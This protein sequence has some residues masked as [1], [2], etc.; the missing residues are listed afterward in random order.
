MTIEFGISDKYQTILARSYRPALR[1]EIS[2]YK[3]EMLRHNLFS[4]DL[5][6]LVDM[7]RT[8][9]L[10]IKPEDIESLPYIFDRQARRAI[11]ATSASSFASSRLLQIHRTDKRCGTLLACCTLEEALY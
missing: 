11:V 9:F 8:S 1:I 2:Y 10:D 7:S 6:Q 4:S 3:S 5:L